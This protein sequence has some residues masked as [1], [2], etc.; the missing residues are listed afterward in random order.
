MEYLD[1]KKLGSCPVCGGKIEYYDN[2][3]DGER[4][5][6]DFICTS[7]SATGYEEYTIEFQRIVINEDN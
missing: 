4:I 3:G 7:C 5:Y 6:Y 2:E 1:I